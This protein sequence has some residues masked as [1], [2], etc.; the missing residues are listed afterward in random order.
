M[1]EVVLDLRQC[2]IERVAILS[3]RDG[4]VSKAPVL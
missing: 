4:L 1:L 2:L 3:W